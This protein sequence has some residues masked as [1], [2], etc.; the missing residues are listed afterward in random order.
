[1]AAV[2]VSGVRLVV[3]GPSRA[4]LTGPCGWAVPVRVQRV[5]AC[6]VGAPPPGPPLVQVCSE[7]GGPASVT[8]VVWWEARRLRSRYGVSLRGR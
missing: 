2:G 6:T 7:S 4:G 1:M 3:R 8:A 5:R